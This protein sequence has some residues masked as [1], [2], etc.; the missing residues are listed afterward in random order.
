MAIVDPVREAQQVP[1]ESI[2]ADMGALPGLL[3]RRLSGR[4]KH[5]QAELRAALVMVAVCA[6]EKHR[7]RRPLRIGMIQ[8]S[9]GPVASRN[10]YPRDERIRFG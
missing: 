6:Y 7:V 5:R 10:V 9:K 3:A 4:V 8:R 1:G 2:A